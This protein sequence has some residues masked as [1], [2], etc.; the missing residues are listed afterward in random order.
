MTSTDKKPKGLLKGKVTRISA[1]GCTAKVAIPKVVV[2]PMYGKRLRRETTLQVHVPRQG[3]EG[4]LPSPLEVGA[5]VKLAPCRRVSKHKA[6][7]VVARSDT[8]NAV[9]VS[10][11]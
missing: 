10:A 5:D 4:A 9:G 1:D 3:E 11:S 8:G 2:H 6:W 7:V